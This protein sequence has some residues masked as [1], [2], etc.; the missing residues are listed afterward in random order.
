MIL[1]FEYT[2][3]FRHGH[4][5]CEFRSTVGCGCVHAAV[6]VIQIVDKWW[7]LWI[8]RCVIC[9]ALYVNTSLILC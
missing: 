6:H 3:L 5:T 4:G 9:G 7:N 8:T 1:L 2:S